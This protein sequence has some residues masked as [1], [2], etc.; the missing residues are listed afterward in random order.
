MIAFF[1]G[2]SELLFSL[3]QAEVTAFR[4]FPNALADMREC[5]KYASFVLLEGMAA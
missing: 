5:S 1:A 2:F 3:G 4:L